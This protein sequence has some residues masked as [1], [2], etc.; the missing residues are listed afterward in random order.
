[1]KYLHI[2]SPKDG[3]RSNFQNIMSS[4]NKMRKIQEF[5]NPKED[6]IQDSQ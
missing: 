3:N 6:L 4:W 2:F 5:S 1:M